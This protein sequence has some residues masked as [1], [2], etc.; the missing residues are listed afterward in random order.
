MTSRATVTER[1]TW[2]AI[3]ALVAVLVASGLQNTRWTV[4]RGDCCLPPAVVDACCAAADPAIT[5]HACACCTPTG[6]VEALSGDVEQKPVGFHRP[7]RSGCCS[8]LEIGL[9]PGL[10]DVHGPGDDPGGLAA[11]G[12]TP[13]PNVSPP[14]AR[15]CL[16]RFGRAPPRPD[17]ITALRACT[18]L[19]I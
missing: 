12:S 4:C 3:L 7:A 10:P 15:P 13:L 9:E 5:A 1:R 18:V 16:R 19:L 8:V 14:P 17:R 6:V 11:F 2:S